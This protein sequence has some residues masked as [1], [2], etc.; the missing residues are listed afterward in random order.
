MVDSR[1]AMISV[2]RPRAISASSAWMTFSVRVSS[3]RS[4]LVED[5]DGGSFSSVR[6]IATRCFSPPDSFKPALA[7]LVS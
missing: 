3:A 6:A 4:R 2:V 1:C 7:D 5:Q